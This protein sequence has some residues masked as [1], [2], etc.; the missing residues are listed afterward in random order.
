MQFGSGTA[1]ALG[2][3]TRTNGFDKSLAKKCGY[4][5]NQKMYL[6]AIACLLGFPFKNEKRRNLLD[7]VPENWKDKMGQYLSFRSPQ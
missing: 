4:L 6:D 5:N 1:A 3:I 2:L 7:C